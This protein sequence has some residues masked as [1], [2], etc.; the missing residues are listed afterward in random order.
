[1]RR[2]HR[3]NRVANPSSK[4]SI[5]YIS[6][7]MVPLAQQ[8]VVLPV[9]K[10]SCLLGGWFKTVPRF[11]SKQ[12]KGTLLQCL[13]KW[14]TRLWQKEKQ[15]VFEICR[16]TLRKFCYTLQF[17]LQVS[18]TAATS[19]PLHC[20]RWSLLQPRHGLHGSGARCSHLVPL[21]SSQPLPL[22]VTVQSQTC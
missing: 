19:V 18:F 22:L 2:H 17:C 8:S 10:P 11:T 12:E 1:M 13:S 21:S 14:T 4:Q 3:W 9:W 15:A 7:M 5:E 16:M 20:K 6:L